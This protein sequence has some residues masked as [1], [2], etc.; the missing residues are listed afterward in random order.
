MKRFKPKGELIPV[1]KFCNN[2]RKDMGKKPVKT[3]ACGIKGNNQRCPVARTIGG[4][5]VGH[6][7]ICK[8]RGGVITFTPFII[9]RFIY[10]FDHG[11][12]PELIE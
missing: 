6:K 9:E 11:K 4:I 1:L 5:S 7:T 3:I 10:D 12:I 2:V 8:I